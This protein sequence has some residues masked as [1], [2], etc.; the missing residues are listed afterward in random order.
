MSVTIIHLIGIPF[1]FLVG[2]IIGGIAGF[3]GG[4][5][6]GSKHSNQETEANQAM[7]E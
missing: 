5:R 2:L 6:A 7:T 1:V 3:F 4:L